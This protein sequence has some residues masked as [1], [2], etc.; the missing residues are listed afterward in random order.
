MA[1][2][3]FIQNCISPIFTFHYY[4]LFFL[5]FKRSISETTLETMSSLL[6]SFTFLRQREEPKGTHRGFIY[7]FGTEI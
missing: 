2:R 4:T 6:G 7:L 3:Y 5:Q 1:S